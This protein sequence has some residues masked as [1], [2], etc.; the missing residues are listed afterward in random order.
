MTVD[1]L[2]VL[3]NVTM[4]DKEAIKNLKNINLTLYHSLT[5]AQEI[6]LVLSKQLQALQTKT[7]YKK[8]E[9][10]K[11][12][13]DKKNISTSQ[14]DTSG[15]MEGPAVLTIPAQHSSTPRKDTKWGQPWRTGW[16]EVESIARKIK[17]M[18]NTE[19]IETLSRSI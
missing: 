6:V 8:P 11:P 7:N 4:E 15:I 17:P 5:Q 9:T 19:E 3:A 18:N 10:E 16:E 1:A 2:Q 12:A 14:R 13:T